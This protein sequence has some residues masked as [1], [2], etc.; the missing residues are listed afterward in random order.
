MSTKEHFQNCYYNFEAKSQLV[1]VHQQFLVRIDIA[2]Y[3]V[4]TAQYNYNVKK[5][6][7]ITQNF[8]KSC[9]I[10]EL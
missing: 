10:N 8:G 6:K 3:I 1:K 7:Y 4:E 9:W 5:L 2:Q